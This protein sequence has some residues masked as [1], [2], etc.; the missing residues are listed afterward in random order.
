MDIRE[1]PYVPII[2]GRPFLCSTCAIIDVKI[3]TLSMEIGIEILDFIMTTMMEDPYMEVAFYLIEV[4]K[5][6][7]PESGEKN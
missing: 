6:E 2:L 5:Q 7:P 4:E 1:D 3:W